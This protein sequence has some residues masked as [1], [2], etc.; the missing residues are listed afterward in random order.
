MVDGWIA[1]EVNSV[2]L[3]HD[4]LL[5]GFR[6]RCIDQT[7]VWHFDHRWNRRPAK[8]PGDGPTFRRPSHFDVAPAKLCDNRKNGPSVA[9]RMSI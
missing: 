7:H 4:T 1:A 9:P 3:D 8:V 6:L 2:R 5:A